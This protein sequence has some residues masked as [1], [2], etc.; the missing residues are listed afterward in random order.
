MPPYPEFDNSKP[1][2]DLWKIPVNFKYI[3]IW[4]G[5]YTYEESKKESINLLLCIVL[6]PMR[7]ILE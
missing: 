5:N 1:Q 7:T 3:Q 2:I 6:L 4:D